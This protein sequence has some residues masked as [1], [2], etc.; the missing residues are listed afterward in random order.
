MS[1]N[2]TKGTS[3]TTFSPCQTCDRAQILTFL[4]RASGSPEPTVANPFID[5]KPS[6][7]YYKAALWATESGL[8]SGS[9]FGA[10]TACTRAMTIDYLWKAAGCP[11]MEKQASFTDVSDSADY[12]Q[13]VAW[14]V[15]R[16]ITVGTSK[17]T[18]TP[19]ATCTRGQIVTFLY[20][21]MN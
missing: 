18:F 7:Y 13:A 20:R 1:R 14:A 15:E 21:S 9:T 3:D 8:I 4:W 12:A 11:T 19:A 2:I 17:T 6:D 16:G 5:I 10:Q